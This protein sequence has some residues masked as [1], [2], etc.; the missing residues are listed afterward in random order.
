MTNT[1]KTR[2]LLSIA[3]IVGVVFI[4]TTFSVVTTVR[5]FL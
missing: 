2:V 5:V 4:I 3:F 1:T